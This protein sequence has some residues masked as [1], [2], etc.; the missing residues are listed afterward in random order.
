MVL[1]P[2]Q[3]VVVGLP[4]ENL[5][6]RIARELHAA[7]EAGSIR[8]LDALAIQKQQDGTIVSLGASDLTPD[9]RIE[10]GA[11]VGG[12]MGY[13]AA[14]EEGL[15]AGAEMGAAAFADQNFGFSKDDIQ[16]VAQDI[17]AGTTG[18]LVLFEHRWAIPL[19]EAVQDAGG[20]VLAQGMVRPET[21]IGLG[22]QLAAADVAASQTSQGEQQLH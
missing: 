21:L 14:G 4:N 8:V 15:E 11:I 9:Q 17:P 7:S 1:G 20:I 2:V 13:G 5:Q 6:G 16:A 18:V 22:A 19:K 12:L 3:L 10:Y